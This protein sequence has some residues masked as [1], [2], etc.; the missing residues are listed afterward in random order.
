MIQGSID[1]N[2]SPMFCNSSGFLVA[3]SS[4]V[5]SSWHTAITY[6]AFS[7]IITLTK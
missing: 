1:K 5:T 3:S 7:I 4:L 2:T 6:Q